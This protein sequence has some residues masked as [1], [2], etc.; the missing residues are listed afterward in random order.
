[1][2]RTLGISKL[3]RT[4]VK[5]DINVNCV[6]TFLSSVYLQSALAPSPIPP[7]EEDS[8]TTLVLGNPM[9]DDISLVSPSQPSSRTRR[10]F[11]SF[12]RSSNS[13]NNSNKTAKLNQVNAGLLLHN[14]KGGGLK[15]P[16]ILKS[17]TG[18]VQIN[19]NPGNG[20]GSGHKSFFSKKVPKSPNGNILLGSPPGGH[21]GGGGGSYNIL[22]LGG[23]GKGH[24]GG[25]MLDPH[26]PSGYYRSGV[27]QHL[28]S[29]QQHRTY[30]RYAV[31]PSRWTD[32]N[33][34][35][36][37]GLMGAK[38]RPRHRESSCSIL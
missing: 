35:F 9:N 24:P 18:T 16:V 34:P 22:G 20:G 17:A 14:G 2:A 8:T 19:G 21:R 28:Q 31:D 23:G 38:K 30:H 29:Q 4:S 26:H 27:G 1:M 36:R 10:G 3:I 7:E 6:F 12:N 5:D 32:P 11:F 37:L 15:N 25:F 33:A 13:N